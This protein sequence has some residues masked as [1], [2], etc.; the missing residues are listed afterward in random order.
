MKLQH[1]L[2]QRHEIEIHTK[3]I[4]RQTEERKLCVLKNRLQAKI[5][6]SQQDRGQPSL[7]ARAS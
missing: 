2:P 1:Q 7:F 3:E 6:Q 5:L 4:E